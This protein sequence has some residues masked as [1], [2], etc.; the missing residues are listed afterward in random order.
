MMAEEHESSK[1]TGG[2]FLALVLQF[3][4]LKIPGAVRAIAHLVTGVG[5]AGAAWVDAAKAKGEQYAQEIRDRTAARKA[6]MAATAKAAGARAARNPEL[7]DRMVDRF[8][9]EELKRQENREAIAIE[10]GKL[11]DETPPDSDTKV[12]RKIGSMR[13]QPMPKEQLPRSYANIGRK[14]WL[15]KSALPVRSH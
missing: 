11:L 13:F 5:D 8:V 9:G 14:Y 1:E 2:G 12:L 15:A 6:I 4:W 7:L 10:T 3:D